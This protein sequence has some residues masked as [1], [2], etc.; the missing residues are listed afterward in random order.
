MK[1]VTDK[2]ENEIRQKILSVKE[3][4]K[5]KNVKVALERKRSFEK[6]KCKLSVLRRR[7][8]R[9]EYESSGTKEVTKS[10]KEKKC[11]K[12]K[13]PKIKKKKRNGKKKHEDE[14]AL[15]EKKIM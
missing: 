6:W 10:G 9:E 2:R 15:G 4:E 1:Q 12:S 3:E 8:N 14:N 13:L 7:K 5:E 11:T